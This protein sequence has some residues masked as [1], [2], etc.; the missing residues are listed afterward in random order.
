MSSIE[1]ARVVAPDRARPLRLLRWFAVAGTAA[2]AACTTA[3]APVV[4]A[5]PSDPGVPV[6]GVHYQKTTAGYES[7][8]PVAPQ[9]WRR[10]NERVTPQPKSEQ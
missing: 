2:L 6:P 1:L 8:R 3:G 7:E 5:D 9:P 10:L 4:G